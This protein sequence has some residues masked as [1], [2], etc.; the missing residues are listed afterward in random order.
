M[1]VWLAADSP[2]VDE[3]ERQV[4]PFRNAGAALLIS[5]TTLSECGVHESETGQRCEGLKVRI[6]LCVEKV[7][8]MVSIEFNT[9]GVGVKCIA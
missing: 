5:S 8:N 9:A 6:K 7:P 1:L 2:A 3:A 4:W